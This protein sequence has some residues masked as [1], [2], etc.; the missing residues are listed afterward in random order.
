MVIRPII[1]KISGW[2]KVLTK[3]GTNWKDSKIDERKTDIIPPPRNRNK[4]N[5]NIRRDIA[6]R[7]LARFNECAP[8]IA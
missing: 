3:A 6:M 2:A 5:A 8:Y 1:N 4:N 7:I